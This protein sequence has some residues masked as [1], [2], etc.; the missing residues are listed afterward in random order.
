M[1]D[2][3]GFG[4][5]LLFTLVVVA[6]HFSMGTER[7]LPEDISQKVLERRA[8][9]APET[10][11]P[12]P[13]NRSIG[14]SGGAAGAIGAAEPGGELE[15]GEEGGEGATS[16][17][18]IPDDEAETYEIEYEKEGETVEVKE[19]QTLLEAG[20]EQG[21]DLP[22]ACRQGQCISC[23]GHIA[24]GPAEDYVV[25]DGNEMLGEEELSEGYTLTCCAYPTA[26]LT[27]QTGETP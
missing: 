3:F 24:D 15:E 14:G 5:G 13:M 2:A 6:L 27:L 26:G 21:W 9:T 25:H 4:L 16:P 23:G 10:E 18:D 1:V 11:F 19:N 7:V 20:E 8:E 17:A 12:E 22:Y